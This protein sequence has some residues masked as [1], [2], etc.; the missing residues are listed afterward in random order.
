MENSQK[1]EVLKANVDAILGTRYDCE[2]KMGA[3]VFP[4]I[5][6]ASRQRGIP[7]IRGIRVDNLSDIPAE[8]LT[9]K[10]TSDAAAVIPFEQ[11]LPLIPPEEFIM[12]KHGFSENSLLGESPAFDDKMLFEL[13]ER[14]DIKI[15]ISVCNSVGKILCE[16]VYPFALLP[17]DEWQGY[18]C[19]PELLASFVQ[20]TAPELS[21]VKEVASEFLAKWTADGVFDG[22]LSKNP[23]RVRKQ[24]AAIY[25][26]LQLQ[27]IVYSVPPESFENAGQKI[28]LA[29]NVLT[30][31]MGT[32][33]D[34]TLL[35]ASCV[36]AVGL[37]PI[38][39]V[40]KNHLFLGVWLE[41]L[42]FSE[43]VTD[44]AS[45][46]TKRIAEGISEIVVV[47]STAFTAG[48]SMN[49]D[50]AVKLAAER[51]SGINPVECIID[52]KR[53]RLSGVM[54][55]PL[56]TKNP[57]GSYSL[58]VP[59]IIAATKEPAS[60]E[61]E[62]VSER[63]EIKRTKKDHWERR[64][65][66]LSLR[67]SLINTRL[68]GNMLPILS[69][70]AADVENA[71]ADGDE[72]VIAPIPVEV[73]E[74]NHRNS[75]ENIFTL[76]SAEDLIRQEFKSKRIRTVVSENDL[77]K[78]LKNLYRLSRT[79]LEE[80]GANTLYLA[81]G[82]LRWFETAQ[83]PR[84]RYAPLLLLPVE[85][86]RKSAKNGYVLRMRDDGAQANVTLLEMLKRDFGIEV[87][88]LDPLPED[89]KGVDIKAAFTAMRKAV[90]SQTNW[91][92]IDGVCLGVFSFAQ[93]VMWNDIRNRSDDLE[94]N[95]IVRSLMENR[96]AWEPDLSFDSG[97][98]SEDGVFLPL[99]ADASQLRA[100]KKASKGES[101]VLHGPPGTGKS[102]TITSLIANA[103]SSGKTVLFVAEKMAALSVVQERLNKL[104]IGDFCLELH[105]NKSKKR[106]VLDRLKRT[107]EITRDV[108]SEDYARQAENASELRKELDKYGNALYTQRNNGL[109]LYTM[110]ERYEREIN[111]KDT[112]V[113]E[114]EEACCFDEDRLIKARALVERLIAAAKIAGHPHNHP[115]RSVTLTEYRQQ[116]RSEL[117]SVAKEYSVSLTFLNDG[118]KALLS[119]MAED[120]IEYLSPQREEDYLKIRDIAHLISELES[121]PQG[122]A[123]IPDVE[124][125][126]EEIDSFYEYSQR[127]ESLKKQLFTLWKPEILALDIDAEEQKY[128]EMKNAGFF[129][130]I[131]KSFK[132]K[133][134]YKSFALGRIKTDYIGDALKKLREYKDNLSFVV[135]LSEKYKD[136]LVSFITNGVVAESLP[137]TVSK[138]KSIFA[139]LNSLTGSDN[140][141]LKSA[142][143][144]RYFA[145]ADAI[146]R[147]FDGYCEKRDI[148]CGLIG[149]DGSSY[150][151]EYIAVQQEICADLIKAADDIK[152][153][154]A[155]TFIR[156]EAVK[157][158]LAPVVSAY[159]N[160]MRHKELIPAMNRGLYGAMVRYTVEKDPVISSFSGGVFNEKVRQLKR[161]DE[162]LKRLCKEEI[163][164]RLASRVPDFT[165]QASQ[166]SELG[167]LQRAI[168]SNARGTS[169]R[170]LFEQLP[171]L[172]PRLC[173][174]MLM[175]PLSAAQ[176]LAPDRE[177][178]D[179]VVFDE[180]SQIQTCKAVGAIARGKSAVIVG[181]PN[182]MPPTA[183]FMSMANDEENP[184][185]EDLESILDDCLALGLPQTH[186][187]WHYRSRHESLIAFSNSEFY[188]NRL[189]T[190][191]SVNDR[192]RKVNLN[193]VDGYFDRGRSRR[194]KEEAKAVVKEI[195]RRKNDPELSK[196]SLGIVTFN[197]AQQNL[198][199][200]L[201]TELCKSDSELEAWANRPDEPLFIKNLENVQGDERDSII[202]SVGYGPDKN[203]KISMNFGP[204]NRD[205]GWR[206]LNVAVTRARCEICVFSSIT[207]EDIDLSRTG[208]RGVSALRDFL[209][210]AEK[211]ELVTL[212]NGEDS[213]RN[214]I[215]ESISSH[216]EE[217]GYETRVNV[218]RSG[219]RVDIGVIDPNNPDRYL[220]GILTDGDAYRKAE[221]T[222]DR[223]ISQ[224][225]VLEGLGW[226]LYRIWSIDW[227][228]SPEREVK[229]LGEYLQSIREEGKEL[230][231]E[232]KLGDSN[233]SSLKK[234]RKASAKKEESD[235]SIY[236]A[237][238]LPLC[239]VTTEEFL[240][241]AYT[242]KI[243]SA[244][245]TV[246][247]KEA[248]ISHSLLC[249]RVLKSFGLTKTGTKIPERLE[250]II[251]SLGLKASLDGDAVIY[252]YKTES[253]SY[254]GYRTNGEGENKR[255]AADIPSRE[256]ANAVIDVLRQQ[257]G[258]P[259]ADLVREVAKR[260]GYS[261]TGSVV[262][263]AMERGISLAERDGKINIDPKG[264]VTVK[265]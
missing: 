134:E 136:I 41:D 39:I 182:Q 175:S 25:S 237:A 206:R 216:V 80:S 191:P 150:D 107:T 122:W 20:P 259:R 184:E 110:I 154:I 118:V 77:A 50:S 19:Y 192:E 226:S 60:L 98:I 244:V 224:A 149:Y 195:L 186:L 231:L 66:D 75:F 96:L 203:G 177:P 104:G 102:Q 23:D 183:F 31:Q 103:L 12:L 29:N 165:S 115:L 42:T 151:G 30:K 17:Y 261:R 113:F 264:H 234:A 222:G 51:L 36:E 43:A 219:Y 146:K 140:L 127:A 114:G 166:S 253:L 85:I 212:S 256:I 63:E 5:N 157:E 47:E 13:A 44:D 24:I 72:F 64:L 55:L 1:R 159:Q 201:F 230:S 252:W 129:S 83:S 81:C 238:E 185:T 101:F 6:Y 49:F 45:A 179:I 249:K 200:D 156:E 173:P 14:E 210:Y 109:S 168:K 255:D 174:C 76:G 65:L 145:L 82:M 116:L 202:I 147:A 130:R 37:H 225:S 213:A 59:S 208:A 169:I 181:D 38:L 67:N 263:M 143:D 139:E 241:A 245:T 218:G 190:F 123:S 48:M 214:G 74:E 90:M 86:V 220:C 18:G 53:A 257:I 260:F 46:V 251:S 160:G 7:A 194:N 235:V 131:S 152:E 68:T 142:D 187:R 21:S 204:L 133:K 78:T 180:A 22:Y 254:K 132:L 4:Y 54:P 70:T 144:E 189:Y 207:A 9:L 92:V 34:L 205:G 79:A 188:D 242:R 167:I 211:E 97:N 232:E 121:L 161:M 178:F 73:G 2:L 117:P 88:G 193:L 108:V 32:C 199:D 8:G 10:V 137:D 196:M 162:D 246:L 27:N 40:Q 111:A 148:L 58:D 172:L 26:G 3:K 138:L 89:E 164:C 171:N 126:C 158:G 119:R 84:P 217:L 94:K 95:P 93:F 112:I 155:Y 11:K 128:T 100:I 33:L 91:D 250:K 209:A 141:R 135:P 153:W 262:T 87:N 125:S 221:T 16:K 99:P 105:S 248:P 106:D 240:S 236:E 69:P 239:K 198:V 243:S 229:K 265:E 247:R 227:W 233:S 197:I 71:L 120:G 52:V 223:E 62:A 170:K 176:Y 163:Y 56:R 258:L 28:R 228:D 61:K 57:D 124:K 35:F 15:T 215:I